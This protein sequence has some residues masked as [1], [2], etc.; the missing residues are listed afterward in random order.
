MSDDAQLQMATL[1]YQQG[2]YD[3]AI[4]ATRQHQQQFPGSKLAVHAAYWLGLS[5]TATGQ[6]SEAAGT[7]SQAAQEYS[8][9]ELAAAMA[10][11]AGEAYR[12]SG[13]FAAA[14]RYYELVVARHSDSSWADDSLQTMVQLA[15]QQNDNQQVQKRA[16]RFA[17]AFPASPLLPLVRLTSAR[18]MLKEGEYDRVITL[19]EP[20][21][22]STRDRASM[23]G[24]DESVLEAAPPNEAPATAT[25]DA[26]RYYL[27]LAFL[28]TQQHQRAVELLESLSD[29]LEPP[30]L[31]DGIRVARASALLGLERHEEAIESLHVYLTSN[32]EGADAEKCRAQLV[33][34]C[35]RLGRWNEV[36][37]V[38]A[39][40]QRGYEDQ[41][42]E[43]QTLYLSTLEYLSE[44]AYSHAQH[45][46]AERLF[47]EL[48][49]DDNPEKYVAQG[50][51]GL[52][53]LDWSRE[54]GAARSA[55]TFERL[56]KRFPNSPLAAEAAMMRGQSLEKAGVPEGALAM[57]RLVLQ[58]YAQSPYASSATLAAARIHDVLEQDREAEPLLRRWLE[59]HPISDQRPA[60]LYQLAWVLVDLARESDADAVFEEIHHHHGSSRYWS[61]ATYRLAE[62]AARA[63]DYERA[64]ALAAEI[65]QGAHEP[66]MVGYALYLRGQ[67]AAATQRW[68]DV[69]NCM[70][71]LVDEDPEN[72]QHLAAEYW[73][74]EAH[75]RLRQYDRAGELFEKLDQQTQGRSDAWV[76]MI[77]LRRAQVRAHR[78]E[79]QEAYEI[80]LAD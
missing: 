43:D 31:V 56:L 17:D 22:D 72:S 44:A 60:A 25:A 4:A 40:I 39:Q 80:A 15:W 30:E 74:A 73:L 24:A 20:M 48:A 47:R 32:P 62:R 11:A 51:S 65:V 27:A 34:T 5:L 64:D 71:R 2:K 3:E 6:Y 76:A 36:E 50:L 67:L 33:V 55:A 42:Y 21:L 35:A 45:E 7:L 10:F 49:R 69:A 63:K 12:R 1:F 9:H 14:E 16:D 29:V 46:L 38:F 66:Q 59:D 52:A 28:G 54:N 8:E 53:W 19:L 75:Y 61:D 13:D 58:R 26:T 68:D 41:R 78:R 70:Q 79:W 18:A 77:P 23:P 37:R 57:Y